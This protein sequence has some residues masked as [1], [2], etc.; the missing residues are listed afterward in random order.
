M[1]SRRR[2]QQQAHSR[3]SSDPRATGSRLT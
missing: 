2:P 1:P 3:T